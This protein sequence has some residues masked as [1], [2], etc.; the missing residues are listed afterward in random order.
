MKANSYTQILREPFSMKAWNSKRSKMSFDIIFPMIARDTE[1]W[2]SKDTATWQKISTMAYG[3]AHE[4]RRGTLD[5][6]YQMAIERM[7][8]WQITA[9]IGEICAE[10]R[11]MNQIVDFLA[12]HR[13]EIVKE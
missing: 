5:G 1:R 13:G 6:G 7:N 9:L 8:G 3:L 10:C 12:A 4:L 11:T 2:A